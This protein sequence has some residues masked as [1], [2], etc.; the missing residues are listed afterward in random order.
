M[1]S[2]PNPKTIR[3]RLPGTGSHPTPIP[4]GSTVPRTGD[5]PAPPGESITEP[6]ADDDHSFSVSPDT[7][8]TASVP[9]AFGTATDLEPCPAPLDDV[10]AWFARFIHPMREEDLDTIAL[11]AVHTYFVM[12]TYTS[13]RLLIDSPVPGSGKTTVL[14]HLSRLCHDAIQMA[15]VT[16]PALLTRLIAARPRTI[17]IDEA[18]RALNPSH[19]GIQEMIA[20]LN[21]GYKRGATR[22]VLVQVQGGGW[23]A[24]EMPTYAAVGMA[25]NQPDL[26]ADTRQRT[27]RV[28][29]M[30]DTQGLVEDTD[31]ELI[32]DQA[33]QLRDG[34][35]RWAAAV[36]EQVRATRPDLPDLIRARNRERWGPLK[37]V[38]LAAGGRWP[39]V[40]DQL[41]LDDLERQSKD[42]SDGL[43]KEQ[44]AMA[45]LRDL[46]A[47]F[48]EPE[49]AQK[50]FLPTHQIIDQLV[51]L[52][53]DV[54]GPSSSTGKQLTPQRLGQL[55]ARGY[56]INSHRPGGGTAPRGYL[57]PD[58]TPL[59]ERL[60]LTQPAEPAPPAEA[61]A[62]ADPP[63]GSTTLGGSTGS[64]APGIPHT[65]EDTSL[66][67]GGTTPSP[68][69]TGRTEVEAQE[70]D[71]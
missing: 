68:S 30:P 28:L 14:E 5:D 31:W 70:E 12:E 21:S 69:E 1:N 53:P 7:P 2:V 63:A 18:D 59:W 34:I 37:R 51:D 38:A 8:V 9:A 61:A 58:L 25:G 20:V 52:H 62:A 24:Q 49:N 26:P 44:P 67:T 60:G 16:S 17:L 23:E 55:L 29:L 47:V 48:N 11:W 66:G 33:G 19:D 40:V 4:S 50:P 43:V 36:R 57:R 65:A 27:I 54:W 13:P 35:A 64:P 42:R 56:R 45:L 10:R 46:Q 6:A 15:S 71:Q 3:V 39:G 41:A 22:P 32:E